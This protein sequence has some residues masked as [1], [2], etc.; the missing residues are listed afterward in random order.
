MD[1]CFY[2]LDTLPRRHPYHLPVKIIAYD[3][4]KT[5]RVRHRFDTYNYSLIPNGGGYYK[6]GREVFVV[7]P[8]FMFT[9]V[10]GEWIEYGPDGH[11]EE[12]FMVYDPES[13]PELARAGFTDVRAWSIS[14]P[15]SIGA[16]VDMLK[17]LLLDVERP[18][19]AD[20]I[21]RACESLLLE[22]RLGEQPRY[23]GEKEHII[24][25]IRAFVEENYLENHDF[26]RLAR[27]YGLSP[28]TFRRHWARLVGEPPW[29]FVMD[30][31]I[32]KAKRLLLESSMPVNEIASSLNFA[33]PLY[34]SRKFR[35]RTGMTASRYRKVNR[36][37]LA[38][39]ERAGPES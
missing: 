33:D 13:L 7:R 19:A 4:H 22:C 31:R 30:M 27:R 9:A 32:Q 14:H 11:W 5:V 23:S 17:G 26:D 3:P 10:P 35:E 29:R 28:T 24:Q 6:R 20:K 8:P 25:K 16:L 34:F 21:D 36:F 37:S 38:V 18:G 39:A 12:I 1:F 2:H 15:G